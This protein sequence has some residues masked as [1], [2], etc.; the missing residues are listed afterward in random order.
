[1][2]PRALI[3]TLML[4][5]LPVHAGLIGLY[6]FEGNANDSSGN[7]NNGIVLGAALTGAGFSGGAYDFDGDDTILLP[8]D[9]SSATLSRVTIGAWVKTSSTSGI[10]AIVSDG[11]DF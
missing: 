11:G 7:G 4:A 1:M 3:F 6:R 9:I 10:H 8:I 2:K 5:T